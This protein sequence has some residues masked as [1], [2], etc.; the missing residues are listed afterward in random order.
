MEKRIQRVEKLLKQLVSELIKENINED[1][2]LITVADVIVTRDLQQAKV[3][4]SLINLPNKEAVLKA[5]EAKK[6]E[7]Q[8]Y[9]GRQ[10]K[11]RYTPKLTFLIDKRDMDINHVEKLLEEIKDGS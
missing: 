1:L 5:L 7:F 11:M 8:R 3:Y 6:Q 9:L 2:G 4:L 10:L